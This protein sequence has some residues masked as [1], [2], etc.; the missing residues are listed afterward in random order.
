MKVR[1]APRKSLAGGAEGVGTLE[2]V[3]R[4]AAA[5]MSEFRI[6]TGLSAACRT[7]ADRSAGDLLR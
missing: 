3:N 2:D 5:G 6:L 7:G 1:A 4:L